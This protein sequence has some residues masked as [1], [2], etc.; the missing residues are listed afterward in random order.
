M[1]AR[2]PAEHV[3]DSTRAHP[4]ARRRPPSGPPRRRSPSPDPHQHNGSRERPTASR[5]P[6]RGRRPPSSSSRRSAPP[7]RR[8]GF[9]SHRARPRE[10]IPARMTSVTGS[11]GRAVVLQVQQAEADA[12]EGDRRLP[13]QGVAKHRQGCSRASSAPRAA[14]PAGRKNVARA[15]AAHH[16][17]PAPGPLRSQCTPIS[18]TIGTAIA[19]APMMNP[20]PS[21]D[22]RAAARSSQTSRQCRLSIRRREM[23]VP[24][25]KAST[26]TWKLGAVATEPGGGEELADQRRGDCLDDGE[27]DR[28]GETEDEDAP[29]RAQ[30]PAVRIE[31]SLPTQ[32]PAC[33]TRGLALDVSHQ[34]C[35]LETYRVSDRAARREAADRGGDEGLDDVEQGEGRDAEL[36]R[37]GDAAVEQRE[38]GEAAEED[39][40]DPDD[41]DPASAER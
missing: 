38:L 9:A 4:Q 29:G 13:A 33:R 7:T 34:S 19:R 32:S 37:A 5:S 17:P 36:H 22:G 24:A 6:R 40:D 27:G 16:D 35:L 14:P 39:D 8:R 2:P 12:G 41:G 11:D 3:D 10:R 18:K 30:R 31:E 15:A 26:E 23:A 28:R 1:L 21:T 25:S 20:K